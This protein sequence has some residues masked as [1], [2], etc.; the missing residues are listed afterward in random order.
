M[1]R[2]TNPRMKLKTSSAA[3]MFK[4]MKPE[5]LS[6][7]YLLIQRCRTFHCWPTIEPSGDERDG[8]SILFQTEWKLHRET[9]KVTREVFLRF[10]VGTA[11]SQ[12]R[13]RG[14]TLWSLSVEEGLA[15][16][17]DRVVVAIGSTGSFGLQ[18]HELERGMVDFAIRLKSEFEL[19]ETT[20]SLFVPMPRRFIAYFS[21]HF[22][23]F[24]VPLLN[25]QILKLEGKT[26]SRVGN[27]TGIA[28][29]RTNIKN[30]DVIAVSRR[31]LNEG[32]MYDEE[33]GAPSMWLID[34]MSL[35]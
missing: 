23:D 35:L 20:L 1:Y 25:P 5:D 17:D 28:R 8:R 19:D 13:T 12:S 16:G 21:I 22:N 27:V 9:S 26:H 18:A 7:E 6:N 2:H 3:W 32:T 11:P 33:N 14:I 4:A 15:L 31:F 24:V 10:Q 30:E 29:D 34:V